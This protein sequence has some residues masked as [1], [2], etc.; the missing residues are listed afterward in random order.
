M[1]VVRLYIDYKSFLRLVTLESALYG[2]SSPGQCYSYKQLNFNCNFFKKYCRL[3]Q[4]CVDSFVLKMILLVQ[5][6]V[7]RVPSGT[8]G[9]SSCKTDLLNLLISVILN[10]HRNLFQKSFT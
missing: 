9:V 6:G 8:I 3:T 4:H 7:D 10:L 5:S 2:K 1:K